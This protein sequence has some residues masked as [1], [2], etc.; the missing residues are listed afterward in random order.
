[1]EKHNVGWAMWDYSGGFSVVT[2]KDG[3]SVLDPE[4]VSALGLTMP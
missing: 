1:L 3:K 4:T 2:Q